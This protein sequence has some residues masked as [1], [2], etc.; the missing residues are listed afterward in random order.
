[1]DSK[2]YID[3]IGKALVLRLA[4]VYGNWRGQV[5]LSTIAE[6]DQAIKGGAVCS[7]GADREIENKR[8]RAVEQ[9]LCA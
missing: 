3:L 6:I 7:K 2:M 1:M 9:A 5:P 8:Y 4:N